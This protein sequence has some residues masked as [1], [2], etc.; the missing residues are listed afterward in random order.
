[1]KQQDWTAMLYNKHELGCML[2]QVGLCNIREQ[3]LSIHQVVTML[4]HAIKQY[5][6]FTNPVLSC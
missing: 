4:K 1:M 5:C 2:Y 6:Y 3:P